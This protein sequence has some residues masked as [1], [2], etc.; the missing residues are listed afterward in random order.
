MINCLCDH[1]LVGLLVYILH[2]WFLSV[3]FC[4]CVCVIFVCACVFV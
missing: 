2:F 4:M 1:V 3:F